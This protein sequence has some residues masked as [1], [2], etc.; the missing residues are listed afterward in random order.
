MATNDMKPEHVKQL[1][2]LLHASRSFRIRCLVDAHAD[3]EKAGV[4]S[5]A[6]Y[7]TMLQSLLEE[8]LRKATVLREVESAGC[9]TN[10]DA[11]FSRVEPLGM[12]RKA[13]IAAAFQL[14]FEG[15]LR[16]RIDTPD[17]ISFSLVTSD[18]AKV[19]PVYVP[20][21][22]VD[23]GKSCS[24]C[25]TCQVT[26]PVGCID[27]D[28]GKVK[29]DMEKCIRCGLCLS[30]CPRALLPKPVM[31]WA[32]KN[33]PFTQDE[34]KAGNIME[35]W[36]AK[37]SRA[38][39]QAVAQDGG[40]SSALLVHALQARVIDA[41]IGTA[42]RDETTWKPEAIVMRTVPDVLKAA[43]TKYV[44]TPSLKLLKAVKGE[45]SIAVVGTPCM[46]QALR[47]AE[48]F[49]TGM[50]DPSNIKYRVGIFCME[51]FTHAGIKQLCE[52]TFSTPLDQVRK[53]NIKEGQ[54]FA[55]LA[56][57]DSKSASMKEVT[58]LARLSCHCCHDLTSEMADISI[59]SIGSPEGWNTVLV[60]TIA[61]KELFD[62]AVQSG[63]IEKKSFDEVQPGMALVKKLSF[64]KKRSYEKT[65]AKRI[66]EKG[67]YPA[68][69]MKL[70]P[71]PPLKKKEGGITEKDA[72]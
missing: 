58:T 7:E 26:C 43:G 9:D 15:F 2:L 65:E 5:S 23:E 36:C 44:N 29:I 20:V 31:D 30:A 45:R 8:E 61:G 49:S 64:A 19:V 72:T 47:K 57:G 70:P 71:P 50:I 1:P 38:D 37:V 69:F 53:M 62:N 22:L 46:M 48:I 67:Y 34:L 55:H 3:I 6:E 11:L 52:G 18:P 28:D 24:G 12:P 51:S 17:V 66:E 41:A 39:I 63:L 32:M 42:K 59:G 54:F 60:R 13:I 4:I 21:K 68:Y 10:L 27:V 35:A 14:A 33:A 25:G 56:K 16:C 40:I